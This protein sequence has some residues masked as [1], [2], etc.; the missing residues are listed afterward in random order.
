VEDHTG[1]PLASVEVR[2]LRATGSGTL[3]DLETDSEGRFRADL[4]NG[5]YR[6]EI[7]KPNYTNATVHYRMAGNAGVVAVRLVRCGV[8]AG[9]VTDSAGKAVRGAR[10][11]A[12]ARSSPAA[13]WQPLWRLGAAGAAESD[14]RGQYRIHGLPAGQYAVAATFTANTDRIGAGVLYYPDSARPHVFTVSGGEEFA[15]IDFTAAPGGTFRVSGKVEAVKPDTGYS[16]ALT[17]ADQPGLLAARVNAASDGSFR[18]EG[19]PGGRYYAFVTGPVIGWSG[20]GAMLG[21]G[22]V[23]GRST[24]DVG[25]QD[26][27][28]LAL[29]AGEA[30]EVTIALRAPAASGVCPG[31]ARIGLR[32]LE[33]WGATFDLSAVV[34]AGR[35]QRFE[36]VPP[37]RFLV[38]VSDLGETC[39]A[40]AE[41]AVDLTS[42]QGDRPVVVQLA[43]AGAIRGRLAGTARAADFVVLLVARDP[44]ASTGRIQAAFP[45]A[46]GRFSFPGL[47]PG[48][49]RIAAQPVTEPGTRWI[50]D[51]ASMIEIEI[52]GG[53][54]TDLELPVAAAK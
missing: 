16:I 40:D 46:E 25:G 24:V 11:V 14:D 9:Y 27:E 32:A 28:G 54:P 22:P 34:T 48:G 36:R 41:I 33:D 12:L 37:G 52:R 47:R 30:R 20:F 45:D 18:F 43:A 19:I 35:E 51:L 21:N 44:A 3:A 50:A 6:I 53:S 17:P 38:T 2:V 42:A 1:N 15:P 13:A 7:A 10:V 26:V 31:S 39:F 4:P 8:I 49:Y 29:T 23:F 5:N